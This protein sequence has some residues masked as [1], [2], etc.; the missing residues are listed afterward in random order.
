[1][2]RQINMTIEPEALYAA[3][4]AIATALAFWLRQWAIT[5]SHVQT[6]EADGKLIS[7]KARADTQILEQQSNA[8][9]INA[10]TEIARTGVVVQQSMVEAV[11]EYTRVNGEHA[12]QLRG[13]VTM[14]DDLAKGLRNVVIG[15]DDITGQ[16]PLMATDVKAIKGVTDSLETNIGETL[17]DQFAPVVTELRSIGTQITGLIGEVQ[18]KDT[19]INSRLT[20]LITQFKDAE[21]RLMRVLEPVV[22]QHI[23]ELVQNGAAPQT[24]LEEKGN[25]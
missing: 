2:I 4:G 18:Q 17:I 15:M 1:M 6:K 21:G 20:D 23:G 24:S 14:M 3:I 11:R 9:A 12:A 16:F 10:L 25:S 8:N 22:I 19:Q 5:R 7:E 13:M